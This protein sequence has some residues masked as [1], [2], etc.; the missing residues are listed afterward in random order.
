[1]LLT[2]NYVYPAE[3]TGFVRQG[4]ADYA[5]N[6]FTLAQ[7]LPNVTVDD[8]VYRMAV[9]GTG[10][11]GAWWWARSALRARTGTT[12]HAFRRGQ[13]DMR[14]CCLYQYFFPPH[15]GNH[16]YVGISN[17]FKARRDQ[18][19]E[20]SWWYGYVDH[21]RTVLQTWTAADCPPG[22]SPRHMAKAAETAAIRQFAPIGNT[23]ENPLYRAQTPIRAQ[24][25]AAI[26]WTP[27]AAVTPPTRRRYARWRAA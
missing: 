13:L 26:G 11:A 9:G 17:D 23:D 16:V 6:N 1:M 12:R 25:Q 7:F 4:L 14:P 2:E 15:M 19:A 5:I 18:H 3:I 21:S 10:L 8:I 22:W 27:A 20:K 24:L